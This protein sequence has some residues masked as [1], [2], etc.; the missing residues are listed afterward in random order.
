MPTIR[1]VAKRAGVA[2]ITVSRVI[3]NSGPV[4]PETRARVEAAIAE[5]HYVPNTLARSLRFKETHTLALILTDIINPFWTTVARG[6]EDTASMRGFSVIVCNTDDSAE[7]QARYVDLVLQKQVD[8]VILVPLPE[9]PEIV[10]SIQRQ[11]VPVVLLDAPMPDAQVDVVRA[12]SQEA[13][14]Q[15]VRYLLDLGHRRIA[16]LAGPQ[17]HFT[18][19]ERV[20]GYRRAMEEAG[21]ADAVSIYYDSYNRQG[22]YRSTQRLLASGSLPT[23]L[24]AANNF[25]AVG[26]IVALREA[27]L[28]VPQDVSLAC[29][30]DI[31]VA[32]MI[33]PFLTVAAQPAYDI[34]QK[35]TQLLLARLAGEAPPEPQE[36]VLPVEIIVRKSCRPPKLDNSLHA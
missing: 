24:V 29:V 19:K 6:V 5:L 25:I 26:A 4:S 35:A 13:G 8:G 31:P 1:D 17:N 27:G 9:A 10:T 30:D 21:L 28:S 22:G 2:P 33:D 16:M 36:I 15:L 32:A 20:A 23:A 14:Y 3:N 34:G 11:R 18:S 12:D 7:K